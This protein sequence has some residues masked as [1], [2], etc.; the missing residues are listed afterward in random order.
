M[1]HT[2]VDLLVIGWTGRGEFIVD[3]ASDYI[4][5]LDVLLSAGAPVDNPDFVGKTALHHAA[6]HQRTG[7]LI[8][9]LLKHKANVDSQ[10]R[11]GASPLLIAIQ[12]DCFDV[13]PVLL[14]AGASLDVTDGEGSSPRSAYLTRPAEVSNVVKGWL[15]QH[16]GK[17]AVL[18]GDRCSQCGI[19]SAPM[20]RC[21]K[22]RSRLYCSLECQSEFLFPSSHYSTH[23][24]SLQ[25]MKASDWKTHKKNCQ[26]F[27]KEDNLLIVK[28]RYTMGNFGSVST[29]SIV[30]SSWGVYK[31][32]NPS[33]KLEANVRDGRNMVIKIQLPLGGSGSMLVYNK[34]RS[35][36]C[37]LDPGE[38][39]TAYSRIK[40]MINGKGILGLKA[41]FA[42]E[43]RSKDELAI[44][45][46]ECLPEA[47][48]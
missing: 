16:Q 7:D 6:K 30:P 10:D 40:E 13:I 45:V 20:K 26:P 1:G 41:Y 32:Q 18:H 3:K 14:D 43:L 36:E 47:R 39:P 46:A 12:E 11:F 21:S 42:A 31:K 17:G 27:N 37:I 4:R 25:L 38:N 33:G 34:K 29:I 8:K 23:S 35:F 15:V 2:Y 9:V 44:N 5:L 24:R 28:P 19:S 22:C 48:F